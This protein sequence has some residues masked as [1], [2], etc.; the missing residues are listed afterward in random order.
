MVVRGSTGQLLGGVK[1]PGC[2]NA[3]E[4]NVMGKQNPCRP[5]VMR[6]A[7]RWIIAAESGCVVESSLALGC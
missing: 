4:R 3:A 2:R 6:W 7:R 1:E 5:M